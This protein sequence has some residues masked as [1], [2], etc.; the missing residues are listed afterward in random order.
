[1]IKH[2]LVP[3]DGSEQAVCGV[4]YAIAVARQYGAKVHGLHVID[5]KLLEGPI[6]RDV[7]ASLGTAPY[8]N[9]EGNISLILEERGKLA[10]D[11]CV[12]LGEEAGVEV[13]TQNVTGLVVRT[14][15][16][17]SELADLVVM[18]R[19]GEHSAW[20]EGVLGSTTESVVRRSTRPVLVTARETPGHDR[21]LVAYDG[22]SNAKRALG[23]AAEVSSG[24]K[25]PLDV[26]V[27]GSGPKAETTLNEARSYLNAHELI[28]R[29]VLREGDPSETIVS[30]AGECKADL[31]VMGAYGHTK[32][33][34]LVVGSTTAYAMNHAP[35][36][37]LLTR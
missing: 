37:V 29:Y 11:V 28:I 15:L 2:I 9:Y 18:G 16:E 34:A 13:C 10:L 27:V 33:R 19:S 32:V 3:T 24:W 12:K 26:L 8:A 31:L 21:F 14:I 5:L 22:S 35:C 36:P 1:M 6:L 4:K 17:K 20:L 30:Y 25:A 7:S 23:V